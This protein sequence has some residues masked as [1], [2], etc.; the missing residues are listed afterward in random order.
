[1]QVNNLVGGS[2]GYRVR[3]RVWDGLVYLADA[4]VALVVL[5]PLFW[6][7]GSSLKTQNEVFSFSWLPAVPQWKNY[8]DGLTV[9][10]FGRYF[11]NSVVITAV[12]VIGASIVASMAGFVFA[13]LAF[14]GKTIMFTLVLSTMMIPFAAIMI[15]SFIIFRILHWI[16]TYAVMTVPSILAAPAFF[17][18]L[19]RQFFMTIPR[20]LDDA[21]K[22]DGCSIYGIYWNILLPLAR[23]ALITVA[24]YA[25]MHNWEDLIRPAIFLNTESMRTVPIGLAMLNV[26]QEEPTLKVN[27]M[28]SNSVL[29]IIPPILLYLIFQRHFSGLGS[30]LRTLSMK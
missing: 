10:D 1:M 9:L 7:L 11:F 27:L 16:N 3:R 12:N 26:V 28:M 6:M 24:I 30:D 20:E 5:V 19:M 14:P 2:T 22:I 13:R 4:A 17:V 29:Y 18:F 25:F 15:P 21:A 8:I 23:P